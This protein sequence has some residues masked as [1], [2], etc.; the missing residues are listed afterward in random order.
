V[1]LAD[2]RT[3]MGKLFKVILFTML[4]VLVLSALV[5]DL[6]FA[7]TLRRYLDFALYTRLVSLLGLLI[8]LVWFWE[9]KTRTNASQKVQRANE[10]LAEV[11]DTVRRRQQ[12]IEQ[13]EQKLNSEY[14]EKEKGLDAQIQQIKSGYDQRIKA[15]NEQIV[16][17]KD[18]IS[19]LMAALKTEDRK[20]K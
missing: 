15:L 7:E 17:L 2:E 10:M 11:E 18:T 8:A 12:A 13:M 3:P 16:E 1:A 4:L 9:R 20:R 14:L 6:P 5:A 19:K